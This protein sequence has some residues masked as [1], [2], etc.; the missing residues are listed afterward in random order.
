M[1]RN[2]SL[3]LLA[4]IPAAADDSKVKTEHFDTDPGWEGFHNRVELKK[5]P[6][7]VQDFGYSPTKFASKENGEIGGKVTRA[8]RPAYYAAKIGPKTLDDKLTAS[9]TFELTGTTGGAGV[10]F[11]FFHAEQAGGS[12]RAVGSLGIDL[13]TEKGGGRLAVRMISQ[14]NKSCGTFVTPF[15]PGKF[16]PTP[17]QIGTRYSW[18]LNY[19]PAGAGGRGQFKFTFHGDAPK[20]GEFTAADIPEAHK[21]EA[22]R[23]FPDVTEFTVDLPDGFKKQGVSFDRFGLANLMKAGGSAMIYFGDLTLD[24]QPIDLSKDP[25]WVGQGNRDKY[26]DRERGGAHDFGYSP[27]TNFAGG[28][29]GELGGSLWRSGHYAY[30]ADKVGPLSLDDR[31]EASGKVILQVGSPDS[32]MFIGWFGSAHKDHPPATIGD[33]VGVHVGG[34]TRVGHYFHPVYATGKGTTGKTKEGPIL[35][36]GKV[37]DFSIDYDPK[38]N[39]G[40]GEIKVT[41]GKE[42]A[43]LPLKK[44]QKAEGATLDRFGLFTSDIGGQQVKIY[45][46]NLKYTASR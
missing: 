29:P 31:L 20:P 25:G 35:T 22:R 33:F 9:G 44:G 2:L 24:G 39:D 42:T 17:I 34:P 26:E 23:R 5:V 18:T 43:S 21:A 30:Y 38:A 10:F 40:L 8:A 7:V 3:L 14:T 37:F 45:L 13:D 12:G 36:P 41:L 4:A 6:T 15:I 28:S 11:G 27:K 1:I 46:D 19:D 16:R 32:D